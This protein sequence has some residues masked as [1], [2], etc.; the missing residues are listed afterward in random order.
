MNRGIMRVTYTIAMTLDINAILPDEHRIIAIR[1]YPDEQCFDLVVEGASM[2]ANPVDAEGWPRV[3]MSLRGEY[4][5]DGGATAAHGH[6]CH[7]PDVEWSIPVA[8]CRRPSFESMIAL[9]GAAA[10][11]A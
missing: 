10:E 2:P 4:N 6:W 7:Q 11:N 8:A 5:K 9:F 3:E 1:H